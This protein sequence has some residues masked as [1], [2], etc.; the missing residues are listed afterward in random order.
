ME[1]GMF[2]QAAEAAAALRLSGSLKSGDVKLSHIQ[3]GGAGCSVDGAQLHL[4]DRHTLWLMRACC[5]L[6][7]IS[8][9]LFSPLF[10]FSL[11]RCISVL[12]LLTLPP[13][14]SG[15]ASQAARGEPHR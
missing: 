10:L 11:F 7:V 4:H 14:S 12:L 6:A 8:L 9:S 15:L 13:S 2:E 3:V 5:C 1:N